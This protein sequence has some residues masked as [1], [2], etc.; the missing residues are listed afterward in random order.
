MF[1]E[2][3]DKSVSK[4]VDFLKEF[5]TLYNL[6]IHLLGNNKRLTISLEDQLK[7]LKAVSVLE[8]TIPSIK[9][10]ITDQ[11]EEQKKKIFVK[12]ESVLNNAKVLL[13]ERNNLIGQFSKSNKISQDENF[14]GSPKK[15]EENISDKLEEESDQSIPK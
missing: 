6:L 10:D 5:S 2:I 9:N 11:S 12:Q 1:F 15:S 4:D 14:Y 8:A 7:L 13:E 3:K